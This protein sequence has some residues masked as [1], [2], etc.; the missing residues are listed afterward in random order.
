MPD[1]D[2]C[3]DDS[4]A[5]NLTTL[6]EEDEVLSDSATVSIRIKCPQVLLDLEDDFNVKGN[7]NEELSI[8]M[9]LNDI[10]PECE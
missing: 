10:Y 8:P 5:Y 9:F 2:F 4:F 7:M 3:G 1:T 6:P